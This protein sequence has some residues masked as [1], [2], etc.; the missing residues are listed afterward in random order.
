VKLF[1][2]RHVPEDVHRDLKARSA[3]AGTSLSDYLLAE[4][5]HVVERPTFDGAYASVSCP[6]RSSRNRR[7]GPNVTED[8]L[9]AHRP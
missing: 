4:L 9:P 1:G 5:R 3:L 7:C 2:S 6:N 8:D